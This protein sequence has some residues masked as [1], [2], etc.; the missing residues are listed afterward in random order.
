M[1]VVAVLD[2]EGDLD[3]LED[4]FLTELRQSVSGRDGAEAKLSHLADLRSRLEEAGC[5]PDTL[6][7]DEAA[8]NRQLVAKARK[9][10]ADSHLE[11]RAMTP[12]MWETSRV[13]LSR[14]ARYGHWEAFPSSPAPFY[15]QF[16]AAVEVKHHITKGRT[17]RKVETLEG[18]LGRLD[19]PR[20]SLPDRLALYRAFH[21]AGMELADRADDSYG[22]VGMMRADAWHAYLEIDWAAAGIPSHSYW[23]DLCELVVWEPYGLGYREETLPYGRVAASDVD[24]LEGILLGLEAELRR[25]Y[26]DFEADEARQQLAW[27]HVAGNRVGRYQAA[28]ERLGTDHWMPIMAMA[29]SALDSSGPAAAADVF[30]AADRSGYHQ[31][32][33]RKECSKMTG[34]DLRGEDGPHLRLVK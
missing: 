18:R 5:A 20:R 25:V 15:E 23:R 11:G 13:V 8:S 28:A 10:V 21:S 27:L 9:K 4:R 29:E 32:Y 6:T 30:R 16:R 17:F 14:R 7:G 24:L 26:L 33:L 2:Y 19:G 1:C 34:V 31:S 22:N 3:A 12:S